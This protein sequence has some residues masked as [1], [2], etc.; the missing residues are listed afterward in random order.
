MSIQNRSHIRGTR[1]V[2]VAAVVIAAG[3]AAPATVL[4]GDAS[5]AA[6]SGGHGDASADQM[7]APG[8]GYHAGGSVRVRRVQRQ[9]RHLGYRPGPVDGRFGPL[10]GAAVRLFQEQ[11]GLAVDGLVGPQTHLA[12]RR[13][14]RLLGRGVGYVEPRGSAR[15]R[16][17][18]RRL[19]AAG[20]HPGAIDGRFGP[21][22]E[23]AVRRFQRRQGLPVDGLVG[24]TT[25]ASLRRELQQARSDRGAEM[26]P[27]PTRRS[28]RP[29]TR[30]PSGSSSPNSS[31]PDLAVIVSAAL[32]LVAAVLVLILSSSGRLPRRRRWDENER[33]VAPAGRDLALP[34]NGGSPGTPPPAPDGVEVFGYAAVADGANGAN[35][36]E[37]RTQAEAIAKECQR[38]GLVL[39]EIVREREPER[40]KWGDRPGLGYALRRIADGEASGLVVAELS[41]VSRSAAE[42]GEV[43]EWF[44][45]S[46]ARFVAVDQDLDTGESAGLVT[47]RTLMAVS[48]WERERLGER[49]RKGLDAARRKGRPGV[50]DDPELRE[51]IARMRAEGMTLQA[52][53]DRFNAEGVPTV[54]GGAKWRT[55]SMQSVVGYRRPKSG[56]RRGGPRRSDNGGGKH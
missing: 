31:G 40:G 17:L 3:L 2:F 15:V 11:Q 27:R 5:A 20:H 30:A 1:F 10:T 37:L 16:T 29:S 43:L 25:Y 46:D 39:R 54:R 9:L 14:A 24:Q 51:R 41:R 55:S 23:T 47:A 28:T 26:E 34:L 50:G 33:V 48:A 42:L 45:H 49:T 53:A 36:D 18:Q 38:R 56:A 44:D 6:G 52:I 8:V 4:A 19:R 13:A 35:G 21:L 32:A 12:L 7:L 22:T